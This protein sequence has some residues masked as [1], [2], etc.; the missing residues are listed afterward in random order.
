VP[1][2]DL[3]VPFTDKDAARQLGARWDPRQ[4]I[5]YVPDGIDPAPLRQWLPHAEPPNVRSA[6]YLLATAVRQCWRCRAQT[7]VCAIMLPAG[8][9]TLYVEDDPADDYWELSDEPT[10]LS[11]IRDLAP[12]ASIQLQALAPH[13]RVDYSQTT[14]SFYWMNH[15]EHCAAKLGD[16]DTNNEFG[17]AFD[18]A[19]AVQAAS[20]SIREIFEPFTASCGCYTYGIEQFQ[21]MSRHAAAGSPAR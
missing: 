12:A 8:H 2:L 4:K 19:N 14:Q 11:Y 21:N 10:L 1:R 5:W 7:G 3:Q 9:E 13:Y 20:I 18:P 15:C 6:S 17:V 16:F